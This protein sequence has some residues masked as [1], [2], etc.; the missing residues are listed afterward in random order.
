MKKLINNIDREFAAQ[1]FN[2]SSQKWRNFF[3]HNLQ[4]KYDSGL[5]PFLNR[6]RLPAFPKRTP[7]QF[8]EFSTKLEKFMVERKFQG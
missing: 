6:D 2:Y 4:L 5:A 1:F 7:T 3:P 8:S